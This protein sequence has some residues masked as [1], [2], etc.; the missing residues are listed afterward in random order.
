MVS[1]T[2]VGIIGATGFIGLNLAAALASSGIPV[3]AVARRPEYA[4]RLLPATVEVISGDIRDESSLTTALRGCT[5][6]VNLVGIIR[7]KKDDFKALH[8]EGTRHVVAAAKNAGVQHVVYVSAQGADMSSTNPYFRTKAEAEGIVEASG[9]PFLILRPCLVLG[10][11]DGFTKTLGDLLRQAPIVPVIG[12]GRYPLRPMAVVDLVAVLL[13]GSTGRGA[14]RHFVVAGPEE[15]SYEDLLHRALRILGLRKPLIHL[16][17]ALVA[18][19][20]RALETVSE[21]PLTSLQLSMLLAGNTGDPQ[22]A[23]DAF[24]L[25]LTPLDTALAR[26]LT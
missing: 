18:P 3:R 11:G 23:I 6:A 24:G 5:A 19:A 16:P 14:G 1:E 2:R 9:L 22:P 8:R 20:V 15:V 10:K 4:R 13:Q 21:P 26:A 17:V 7:G 25:T 12:N